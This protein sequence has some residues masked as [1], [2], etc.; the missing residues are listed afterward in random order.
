MKK[1]FFIIILILIG[2][3]SLSFLIDTNKNENNTIFVYIDSNIEQKEVLKKEI[4]KV[5]TSNNTYKTVSFSDFNVRDIDSYII[6]NGKNSVFITSSKPES[7]LFS[8][9]SI[10]YKNAIVAASSLQNPINNISYETFLSIY[11]NS[12][13]Q[14]NKDVDMLINDNSQIAIFSYSNLTIKVKPLKINGIFP[15]VYNVRKGLYPVTLNFYISTINHR[16]YRQYKKISEGI[17]EK[18]I[19]SII[20]GGDIMLGRAVNKY[21][22]KHGIYYPFKK[23]KDLIETNDIAFANLES[24]LTDRGVKYYPNKGIYFRANPNMAK[25]LKWSGFDVL[26]LANNHIFDWGIIGA[27]D[28]ENYLKSVG[29]KYS[30]IGRSVKDAAKPAVFNIGGIKICIISIDDIFPIEVK[31]GKKAMISYTYD[32]NVKKEISY[33]KKNYE[34]VIVS[35]H[36]GVEYNKHPEFSKVQRMKSLIDYGADIV[37]GSHPHV[38]Q[39]VEIYNNGLI[40]YSLGN[41]IFDQNWSEETSKGLLLEVGFFKEKLIYF[42]P[43]FINIVRG[44]ATLINN[45]NF[46]NLELVL[47]F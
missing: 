44:Q 28:T 14:K 21:V 30:G 8:L 34:V 19:F 37:F 41:L 22:D 1:I 46:K 15:S 35:Y 2:T 45:S 5:F 9:K 43:I 33:L 24:P 17:Q 47:N 10:N 38:V 26:S 40:A 6:S 36:T 29:I 7:D 42:R 16:I 13:N 3:V 39:D 18:A 12:G 32:S 23:I 31:N 20:A 25:A 27:L 4:Y 11:K